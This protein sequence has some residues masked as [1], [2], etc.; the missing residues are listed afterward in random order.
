[1]SKSIELAKSFA[2]I[3]NIND[4][5]Q[6]HT[7]LVDGQKQLI[8]PY[9][10]DVMIATKGQT[11]SLDN[12]LRNIDK[13][14]AGV[15][16]G[17]IQVGYAAKADKLAT[18]RE[19][20]LS[21]DVTGKAVFDGSKGITL[22]VTIF[23]N[24]HKHTIDNITELQG[25]L[26]QKLSIDHDHPE[27]AAFKTIAA[28]DFNINA[29][30][31]E[32]TLNFVAGANIL[33]S[34]NDK[35][36]SIKIDAVMTDVEASV[37]TTLRG[38]KIQFDAN[39]TQNEEYIPVVSY[40]LP[41]EIGRE[42]DFHLSGSAKDFDSRLFIHS[43]GVLN[44]TIDGQ[45]VY[46]L[47]H[48]GN[49]GH[50]SGLDADTLDGKHASSFSADD[51]NHDDRYLSGVNGEMSTDLIL[52]NGKFIKGRK[53]DH[54][55]HPLIGVSGGN[56]IDIG[57]TDL[58]VV[59]WS[60]GGPYV[61]VGNER[62][63]IYHEGYKPSWARDITEIPSV[64]PPDAHHHSSS[65]ITDATP[66]NVSDT[67]VRRD[68]SG[69]FVTNE[70][71]SNSLTTG[72]MILHHSGE[73]RFATGDPNNG[74]ISFHTGEDSIADALRL[75]KDGTARFGH[76]L[77]VGGRTTLGGGVSITNLLTSNGWANFMQGITV[78]GASEFKNDLTVRGYLGADRLS[79]S[80]LSATNLGVS[81]SMVVHGASE[82][83]SGLTIDG[84]LRTSNVSTKYLSATGLDVSQGL[85]AHG[86]GEFKRD[87]TVRGLLWA[88]R[89]SASSI[90]T[91]N[92][93][94]G[95]YLKLNTGLD[96]AGFGNKNNA[97]IDTWY[98]FSV[99]NLCGGQ[100]VPVGKP[101]FSVNA[102]NGNT[103]AVGNI[104]ADKAKRV[105]HEGNFHFSTSDI[106][107][108]GVNGDLWFTY[109]G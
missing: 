53:S 81:Q 1:M 85:T 94:M 108:G 42:I 61:G 13:H 84:H 4:W 92:V 16:D 52:S 90:T 102:R 24:S 82:F 3:E 76:S 88:P 68:G 11:S 70:L 60:D 89:L 26:N 80:S 35:D 58:P 64:F 14:I 63:T 46:R 56:V 54:S 50:G 9:T 22:P 38:V 43:D 40:S 41:L 95:N 57:T 97:N 18:P 47:F 77:E 74:W 15:L 59:I 44:Y 6:H 51:H 106:P 62:K 25:V 109:E 21:G 69:N 66:H 98:G 34:T 104:Y 5:M 83:K 93:D 100:T 39:R 79:A 20:S 107:S 105:Y 75:H 2:G 45:D 37:A 101:A 96:G 17:S 78:Y 55:E 19:I 87:L 65:E 8:I 10:T 73:N 27:W 36:K 48:E 7:I 23:D 91:N 67:I 30:T 29:T 28:G 86:A 103:Y 33:F 99:S 71:T 49:D 32:D 31:P 72:R 12:D